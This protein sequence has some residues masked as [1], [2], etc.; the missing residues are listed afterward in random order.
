MW[1]SATGMNYI[2]IHQIDVLYPPAE[3]ADAHN[4]LLGLVRPSATALP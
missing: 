1:E 3:I 4:V 2:E